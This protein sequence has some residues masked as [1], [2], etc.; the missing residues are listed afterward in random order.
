MEMLLVDDDRHSREAVAWFLREQEHTVTECDHAEQALTKWK[1]ADYPLILSDIQMPGMTG[2]DLAQAVTGQTDGWRTD[3]VLFTGYGDM[4]TAVAALRAGAY[5]YLLKPVDAQELAAIVQRVSE[6]Q[7]LL[8]ENRELTEN[9]AAQVQSATKNTEQELTRMRKLVAETVIGNVGVFSAGMRQVV[10]LAQRFHTDR[11][12]TVL[13]QGET[14]TGK[15]VVARIIHY[16]S[17]LKAPSGPLV[18]LNC[19]AIP[20]NLFESELFGYE[21]GSFSGS[22]VRGQKGKLDAAAGGT[23]FLDEIAEM[24]PEMQAKLLRVLEAKEYYRVGGLKKIKADVRI[25][26][27]TNV[28]LEK[29]METGLFRRDLYYRLKIGH[30]V[31][32]PLRARREEIVPLAEMFLRDFAQSKKKR[33]AGISNEARLLL[34]QYDWPGNVREL[35]N[36]MEWAVFMYDDT[37]LKPFHLEKAVCDCSGSY[38]GEKAADGAKERQVVL[39]LPDGGMSLKE[40]NDLIIQTVLAAH[41]GNQ[42]ATANYLGMSLR[43]LCYRLEQMRNRNK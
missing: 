34:K 28:D 27:A 18:E 37:E 38:S 5:D 39:P 2:I 33:F 31:I 16:G 17:T 36:A 12:L 9:F 25:I 14:G 7:A 42:K 40:Y 1:Q 19:A 20:H 35:R 26:C 10:E 30:V 15:E 41:Q 6:H 24:P 22:L 8:R 21:G 3:V 23:L 43:A 13:I 11:T 32:P 4:K 29:R